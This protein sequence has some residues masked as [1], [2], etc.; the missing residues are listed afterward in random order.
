MEDI[1]MKIYGEPSFQTPPPSNKPEIMTIKEVAKYLRIGER[2]AYKLAK[3]GD[4]PSFK[5]VNKWRFDRG[6]VQAMVR[7]KSL[8]AA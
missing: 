2:S 3:K 7:Q 6:L 5:V 8:G 1:K 4:L